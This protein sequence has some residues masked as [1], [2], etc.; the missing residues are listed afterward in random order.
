MVY[1]Q[2]LALTMG[3][4]L[5]IGNNLHD[6]CVSMGKEPFPCEFVCALL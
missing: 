6:S 3:Q 5:A 2:W 4:P 1:G